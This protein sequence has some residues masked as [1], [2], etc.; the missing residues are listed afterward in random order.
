[1]GKFLSLKKLEYNP[2]LLRFFSLGVDEASKLY[3]TKEEKY[4]SPWTL[5][6]LDNAVVKI[7]SRKSW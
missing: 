5:Q 3:F 6:Q 2:V 4:K 1:M 7:I